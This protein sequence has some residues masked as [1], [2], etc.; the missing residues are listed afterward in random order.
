MYGMYKRRDFSMMR[1]PLFIPNMDYE[2]RENFDILK[3]EFN[4]CKHKL[5]KAIKWGN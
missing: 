4:K 1:N 3:D 2:L 5:D